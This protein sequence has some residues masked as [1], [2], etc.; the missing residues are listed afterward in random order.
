MKMRAWIRAI[1]GAGAAMI[2]ALSVPSAPAQ[3]VVAQAGPFASPISGHSVERLSGALKLDADQKATVKALYSGYRTAFKKAVEEG[4]AEVHAIDEKMREGGNQD[5]AAHAKDRIR[6]MRSFVD[7][8]AKLEKGFLED[9]KAILTPEQA[10][11]FER[12]E[13]TRRRE[14]GLKFAFIA[15]EGVD[16]FQILTDIKLDRDSVPALKDELDQYELELDR[17]LVAKDKM[18]RGVFDQMEKLEG[19]E[20]D[21]TQIEKTLTEFFSMGLRVRDLSRQMTRKT[22]SLLPADKQEAFDRAVK[23]AS[24]PRVYAESAVE[25]TIKAAQGLADLAPEQKAELGSIAETY[26][27]EADAAN[28][29]WAS[30]IEEKQSKMTGHVMEMMSGMDDQKP[31]DPLKQAREARKALD[32]RTLGRV[33]QLLKAE[34]KEKMPEIEKDEHWDGREYMP[35]F[36]EHDEWEKWKKE[37]EG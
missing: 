17:A 23:R 20:A 32:E 6:I 34:Q 31:D 13:R 14:V 11:N 8:I 24:F 7:K 27:R 26:G 33:T 10:S 16:V 5:Y 25:K 15:G 37:D 30:A 12:A 29:R 2:L 21:P 28:A 18:L 1:Q 3:E 36:D 4:D 19:P 9:L 35:D 22:T